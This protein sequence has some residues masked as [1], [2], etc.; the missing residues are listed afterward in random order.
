MKI[1]RFILFLLFFIT[2][3]DVLITSSHIPSI[4]S[5]NVY[6]DRQ[7]NII[8]RHNIILAAEEWN[9][10]T[11]NQVQFVIYSL[12]KKSN[13]TKDDLLIIK[14]SP[15]YPDI[16]Y[17]DSKSSNSDLMLGYYEDT[18]DLKYIEIVSLRIDEKDFK[19]V[20]MHELGHALGLSHD[21][22]QINLMNSHIDNASNHITKR[23][24][25]NFCKMYIC[26]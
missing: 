17:L 5:K 8:E 10:A 14:V 11:N 1:I 20:V 4:I 6:V 25:Y 23:D 3:S 19:T 22:S 16:I 15:D 12:P 18:T 13:F 9:K 24:I 7:F 21:V 26:K 2:L